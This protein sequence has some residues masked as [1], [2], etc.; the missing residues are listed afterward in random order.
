MNLEL[1]YRDE[2]MKVI[3]KEVLEATRK[4]G[5]G[6]KAFRKMLETYV[7]QVGYSVPECPRILDLGC[8]VCYEAH[9]LSSYFGN[10]P[11]GWDSKDVLVVGIDTDEK[12]LD[13]SIKRFEDIKRLI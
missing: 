8:G 13:V 2:T 10:Q 7:P 5:E 11:H 4:V 12:F 9:V 3:P 6:R 1:E